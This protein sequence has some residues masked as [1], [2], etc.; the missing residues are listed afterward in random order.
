[1]PPLADGSETEVVS[2]PNVNGT[3]PMPTFP[4]VVM[5]SFSVPPA[6]N[7]MKSAGS[8]LP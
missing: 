6:L 3:P 4:A 7:T 1:M 5:R 2:F 8:P